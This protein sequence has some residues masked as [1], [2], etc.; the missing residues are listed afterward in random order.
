MFLQ[1]MA[2][3]GSVYGF[4]DV[5]VKLDT[6][7]LGKAD[8]PAEAGQPAANGSQEGQGLV[9]EVRAEGG[10]GEVAEGGAAT[11]GGETVK[12]ETST[13]GGKASTENT[14]PGKLSQIDTGARNTSRDDALERIARLVR[15]EMVEPARALPLLDAMDWRKVTGYVQVYELPSAS[16]IDAKSRQ[17]GTNA[18]WLA[19]LVGSAQAML[20]A[21]SIDQPL[22]PLNS[23]CVRVTEVLTADRWQRYED[24]KLVAEGK[25][26]LGVIPLAHVQNVAVP[27]EYS[28]LSDV[29]ALVP[30]QDELNTRLSDRAYRISMQS[31]KMYLGIGIE[32]F[33]TLPVGPGRMFVT[34]NEQASIKEFGGDSGAPSEDNHID[35]VREAM[36]KMSGVSPIAAGAIK[37]RV[38]RLTSAAA[39]RVTL[40]SL[41]AR[42]E[43][44][45]TTYGAAIQKMMEL[46]L[47]WLDVAGV[48]KTDPSER[49]VE[50]HWASPI[51][52]N[53]LETLQ[54][55]KAKLDL[56]VPREV[57][58][59]ELGY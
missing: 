40:Q 41:L 49:A 18:G 53:D 36:D 31:F 48:F 2:L 12:G 5:L 30:L 37:G 8:R 51:P 13:G 27:F 28:G 15:F 19:K 44:K 56:G 55:G 35:D 25:N 22:V 46:A 14:A 16:R 7:A 42:T 59:R 29:E 26:S 21:Q 34:D 58:L 43:K 17:V 47:A 1:Q 38:G 39:L 23:D 52:E 10:S 54:E 3:L 57:V 50:L 11:G 20:F 33:L 6:G 32:N 24:E 45:R 4:V 9:E